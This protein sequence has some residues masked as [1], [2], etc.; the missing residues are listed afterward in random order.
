MPPGTASYKRLYRRVAAALDALD[1]TTYTAATPTINDRRRVEGMIRDAINAKDAAVRAA[2][3]MS[4]NSPH[5]VRYMDW[6]ADL[7][8]GDELPDHYGPVGAVRIKLYPAASGYEAGVEADSVEQINL[9]RENLGNMF[10]T[11][12][13]N[14]AGSTTGGH[15][16]IVDNSRIYLTGHKAQVE[17][18][19]FDVSAEN[20]DPP[21]LGSPDAFEDVIYAGS[22]GDLPMEGDD[23]EQAGYYRDYYIKTLPMIL[24]G[25]SEVPP[26]QQK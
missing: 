18:A 14:A 8:H 13:H 4:E 16:L 7:D 6:S 21:V 19:S 22:V 25:A 23:L 5:R 11:L 17:I 10:G 26:L 24:A 1:R 9:W 20:V 15:F 3:C 12:A 2:I